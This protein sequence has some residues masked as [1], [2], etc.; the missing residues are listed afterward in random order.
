VELFC[1]RCTSLHSVTL[2]ARDVFASKREE[3][4]VSHKPAPFCPRECKML[5]L[6]QLNRIKS[7]ADA[8]VIV[9]GFFSF[10]SKDYPTDLFCAH[11]LRS[12]GAETVI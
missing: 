6:M 9:P 10:S 1:P 7:T 3:I 11:T 8:P 2:T 12:S 4:M 5:R